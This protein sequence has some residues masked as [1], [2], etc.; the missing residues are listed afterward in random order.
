MVG[1]SPLSSWRGEGAAVVTQAEKKPRLG[2]PTVFLSSYRPSGL[3]CGGGKV[4]KPLEAGLIASDCLQALSA[5]DA[6]GC[7]LISMSWA[8]EIYVWLFL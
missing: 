8:L 5:S 4:S 7:S 1:A 2:P 6:L 3:C